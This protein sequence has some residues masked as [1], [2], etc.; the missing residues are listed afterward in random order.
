MIR[1][2]IGMS[3]FLTS[4]D[5]TTVSLEAY[6]TWT[7]SVV[8]LSITLANTETH[9]FSQPTSTRIFPPHEDTGAYAAF[10]R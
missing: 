8:N 9:G 10:V 3:G 7:F 2:L 4:Y 5:K 1:C 6:S